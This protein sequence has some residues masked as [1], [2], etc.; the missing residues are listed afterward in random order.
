LNLG[1]IGMKTGPGNG[2]ADHGENKKVT[3]RN[4]KGGQGAKDLDLFPDPE[5][6]AGFPDGSM[7]NGPVTL[8]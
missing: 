7:F 6:F 2:P 3:H 1:R 5:F 4:V 8:F